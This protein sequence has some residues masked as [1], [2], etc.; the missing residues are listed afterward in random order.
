MAL[1][2]F[3]GIPFGEMHDFLETKYLRFNN[4]EFIDGDPVSIPHRFTSRQD[5]EIAGF[6]TATIAWGRRDLILRSAHDLME[7]MGNS[8]Y[9]F[10]VEGDGDFESFGSYYYRTFNGDDTKFFLKAL[11]SIYQEYSSMEDIIAGEIENGGSLVDGVM[12]LREVFFSTPHAARSKKHFADISGGAAGKRLMMFLRWMVRVDGHGVDFG[13]WRRISPSQL[14]IPLDLHSGNIARRLGL[15]SRNANDWKSVLELTSL[16]K[17]FDKNDPVK[18]D[19]ALFGL[20][21]NEEF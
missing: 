19:F 17:E 13:L 11:R 20:G 18:Y 15:L 7:R 6:L 3:N 9:S 16:L 10:L 4:R 12:K 1:R 5:I 2:T 8:P 14:Y 21:V